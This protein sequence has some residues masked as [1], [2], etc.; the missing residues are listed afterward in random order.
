M[1]Q[2]DGDALTFRHPLVRSAVYE[3]APVGRRHSH[4][5]LAEALGVEQRADRAL[6][7]RAMAT[8]TPDEESPRLWRHRR[9]DPSSA[10]G[11]ASA[12]SAFERA[13]ELSEATA[14]AAR[15]LRWQPRQPGEED[16][17]IGP[18]R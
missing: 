7:H 17:P 10:G 3:S 8:L 5:A 12:A 16:R 18:V 15:A 9:G 11:H 2:V 6:W 14:L 13:A 1:V 4:A